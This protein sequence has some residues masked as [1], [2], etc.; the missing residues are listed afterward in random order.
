MRSNAWIVCL[1][2]IWNSPRG[3]HEM[4]RHG[5]GLIRKISIEKFV[6]AKPRA[7]FVRDVRF[8]SCHRNNIIMYIASP[9][10]LTQS[11]A[12][13]AVRCMYLNN[14]TYV[15]YFVRAS[16]RGRRCTLCPRHIILLYTVG[17][18]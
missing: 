2:F 8:R 1:F 3:M 14:S 17:R 5:P 9:S 16:R 15:Y 12:R 10:A 4:T 11:S 18:A 13:L 7:L 6:D